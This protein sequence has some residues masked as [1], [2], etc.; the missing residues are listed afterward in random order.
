MDDYDLALKYTL[1]LISSKDYLEQTIREKLKQR[2]YSA[3]VID[4]VIERLQELKYLDN[5]EYIKTFIEEKIRKK[6]GP[7]KI[8]FKLKSLGIEEDSI[9]EHL[10][11]IYT[12]E[13]INENIAYWIEHKYEEH[14]D[15]Q[16][17]LNFC[18]TKGFRIDMVL[19]AIKDKE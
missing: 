4:Q 5:T 8:K 12:E 1:R 11:E 13:L 9:M 16:K 2:K 10:D 18:R 7:S 14:D 17:F 15:K 3:G 19:N 6:D